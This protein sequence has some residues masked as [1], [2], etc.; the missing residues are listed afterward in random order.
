MSN[1]GWTPVDE[2]AAKWTPV[3]EAA[4]AQPGVIDKVNQYAAKALSAAGLPTSISNIPEWLQHLTGT[5]PKSEPFWEPIR[6]AIKEP[7]EENIVAAVPFVGP[8]SVA[9]SKD[10]QKGDVGGAA[11]T[12]IGTIAGPLAGSEVAPGLAARGALKT[13]SRSAV[14]E[15]LYQSALKPPPGSYSTAEVQSMVKTGLENKIPVSS[16]GI[17]KLTGLVKGLNDAV[18]SEIDAGS[19]AGKT[20]NTMDVASRLGGTAKKFATQVNPEADL[21]AVQR[22]GEEFVRNQPANIPASQ[23]QRLKTGTYQQLGSKAYGELGSA[24]IE[25]QKALARGIKEELE[26]QFP[27]IKGL[28]AAQGRLYNLQPALERAVRR[29]DNHD[30]ISL[31]SKVSAGAGAALGG[32]PGA[33]AGSIMEKVLGMPMVKSKLAIAINA[34]SKGKTTFGATNARLAAYSAALAN[35]NPQS[36]D[37]QNEQ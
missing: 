28:N 3:N 36:G 2:S 19:A 17:G 26:A 22:A 21:A 9:M 1:T 13:A 18:Q 15:K 24:T 8:A 27:E 25:A 12:L 14:A 31:G 20:I 32:A 37:V 6:K 30:I 16:E 29:I 23:A 5:H 33:V 35:A 11:S 34:A 7:T 4:P 10:V